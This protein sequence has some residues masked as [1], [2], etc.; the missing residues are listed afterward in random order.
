MRSSFEKKILIKS[1]TRWWNY[2]I[3]ALFK[4]FPKN[5]FEKGEF[6]SVWLATNAYMRTKA[7]S[8]GGGGG[9][10]SWSKA[11]H[12]TLSR[13]KDDEN[14]WDPPPVM[15]PPPGNPASWGGPNRAVSLTGIPRLMRFRPSNYSYYYLTKNLLLLFIIFLLV[16]IVSFFFWVGEIRGL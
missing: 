16:I 13:S 11:V 10:W 6:S 14:M 15:Y 3:M 9:W 4:H 12:C 7:N 1:V 2:W 8:W 5:D